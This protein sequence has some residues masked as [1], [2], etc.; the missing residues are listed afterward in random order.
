MAAV[1][2]PKR[3]NLLSATVA[4]V[5][6]VATTFIYN[7]W[8]LDARTF[9]YA[10]DWPML[11]YGE[12]VP[13]EFNRFPL[14][15]TMVYNDRPVGIAFVMLLYQTFGLNHRAFHVVLLCLHAINCVLLYAIAARYTTR[16]G[17]LLAALL[18][19]VWFSANLAAAWTAA[20][21]DLL[22]ATLCLAAVLLRQLAIKSGHRIRYDIAGA[23]CYLLAIRTK[24][25]ALG[26]V[27]L[28][29]IMN[30]LVER[31]SIRATI[32]Q[33]L[34]YLIVFAIYAVR[35]ALIMATGVPPSDSPYH[36]DL[37]LSGV[38]ASVGFYVKSLFYAEND[39]DSVVLSG[40]IA[41]VGIG[42]VRCA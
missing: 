19:S 20:I 17:A 2:A 4:I 41:A 23:A 12:S 42:T 3:R 38:A 30:V 21:F 7:R 34:P 9:F 18:A 31:Q 5:V 24:E 16:G 14:L 22:G 26:L 40:V 6:I 39:V 13:W 37:S 8:L 32:R 15:P 11:W 27:A 29:F 10:D 28:L 35:Y 36:L 1:N 25:F 33:L